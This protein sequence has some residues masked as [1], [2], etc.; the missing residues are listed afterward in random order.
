MKSLLAASLLTALVLSGCTTTPDPQSLIPVAQLAVTSGATA[1]T[2]A[3]LAKNPGLEP[4]FQMGSA[5]IQTLCN[6]TNAVTATNIVAVLEKAGVTNQP[7]Q[8]LVS[9]Q[10]AVFNSILANQTG[11]QAGTYICDFADWLSTGVNVGLALYN[12]GVK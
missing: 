11:S 9:S 10:A 2:L 5:A 3:A 4:E 7:I 12:S 8:T 6:G 1:G